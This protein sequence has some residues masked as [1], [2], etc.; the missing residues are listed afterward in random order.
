MEDFADALTS[1][2][3]E[4]LPAPRFPPNP[5]SGWGTYVTPRLIVMRPPAKFPA[6]WQSSAK[7]VRA[8][9]DRTHGLANIRIWNL[10]MHADDYDRMYF[11]PDENRDGI[12][13][14]HQSVV[15]VESFGAP[16]TIDL[17]VA[18][19]L[20]RDVEKWLAGGASRVAVLHCWKGNVWTAIAACCVLSWIDRQRGEYRS[21]AAALDHVL[22]RMN[23]GDA[24]PV[25][26]ASATDNRLH[27]LGVPSLRRFSSYFGYLLS[28]VRPLSA[29]ADGL[30]ISRVI[31]NG[32][33]PALASEVA[34]GKGG[35]WKTPSKEKDGGGGPA[36]WRLQ[37][38]SGGAQ[39]PT[40]D[41]VARV[42]PRTRRDINNGCIIFAFDGAGALVD[43]EVT[44]SFARFTKT[45]AGGVYSESSEIVARASFWTG[46][47]PTSVMVL[48]LPCAKIDL[49]CF[50]DRFD[51]ECFVD[52]VFS[53]GGGGVLPESEESE[54][55]TSTV[56]SVA[57]AAAPV[58][59]ASSPPGLS[60]DKGAASRTVW[61]SFQQLRTPPPNPLVN[62]SR[63]S[64][65]RSSYAEGAALPQTTTTT[66][67]SLFS[68]PQLQ[69]AGKASSSSAFSDE[70][71]ALGPTD[72]DVFSASELEILLSMELDEPQPKPT[73]S[74]VPK[75]YP[76]AQAQQQQ[77]K[78]QLMAPPSSAATPHPPLEPAGESEQELEQQP[79]FSLEA[80]EAFCAEAE[81]DFGRIAA[82]AGTTPVKGSLVK[83]DSFDLEDMQAFLDNM[84]PDPSPRR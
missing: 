84:T 5:C 39:R 24:C 51:D 21:P 40:S 78:M 23:Q 11:E 6:A 71:A 35:K 44:C 7:T 79:S 45:I 76:K 42:M 59:S 31:V 77:P 73:G 19:R 18:A 50:D 81:N 38:Y 63:A 56:A 2:R 65:A 62:L 80:M 25:A 64:T 75:G 13:G 82:G 29:P 22:D 43:G 16:P 27:R 66:S 69:G 37:V 57:A 61:S 52:V 12:D 9:L 74:A 70:K 20:C 72:L 26:T 83:Q 32:V 67:A 4:P 68:Q 3:M 10:G 34:V 30:R 36:Q 48:R 28:K 41:A 8:Y 15:A 58:P 1:A 46:F 49:A 54:S 53:R 47:I 14:M 17:L 60:E 33:P 55:S